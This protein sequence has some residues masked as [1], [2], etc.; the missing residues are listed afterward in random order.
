MS[1]SQNLS[2]TI[3]PISFGK[4]WT[5]LSFFIG[6]V[7]CCF[8]I[9]SCTLLSW[10]AQ[11]VTPSAP[12]QCCYTQGQQCPSSATP[13]ECQGKA[14]QGSHAPALSNFPKNYSGP[15]C[16]SLPAY[17]LAFLSSHIHTSSGVFLSLW[18]ALAEFIK[19]ISV[20]YNYKSI[21]KIPVKISFV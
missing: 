12:R 2:I 6:V 21:L 5:E 13:T 16:S 18:T 20:I 19:G 11:A 15:S 4:P 7:P 10:A 14:A 1:L 17:N 9:P 8:S 3:C